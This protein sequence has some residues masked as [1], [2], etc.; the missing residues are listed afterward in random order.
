MTFTSIRNEHSLYEAKKRR[1]IGDRI[2]DKV[3]V[4]IKMSGILAIGM[5]QWIA[6]KIKTSLPQ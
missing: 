5:K 6:E 4:T 1:R 2:L 3:V